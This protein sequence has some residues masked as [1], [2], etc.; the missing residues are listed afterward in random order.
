[1]LNLTARSR[2]A[3]S[4]AALFTLFAGCLE[5]DNI[6][7]MGTV[8]GEFGTVDL[9]TGDFTPLG[10]SGVT[11]AGM[12]VANATLYGSSYH[13]STGSLYKID[14]T[15]GS[16]AV[17]GTSSLD[18]DD[19]G[20]TTSGLFAVGLDR[21]LYSINAT[22]GAPTLI[23]PIG[24]SLG[25]WRSLSTNS[26]TLYFATGADLYTLSTTTGAATLVGSMGGP[27]MGAMLQESGILYGGENTPGFSVD[28]LN[29]TTG[30]ATTGPAV[31]G[32]SSSFFA[33]APNPLPSSPT[34]EPGTTALLAIGVASLGL[35][36]RR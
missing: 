2:L 31:T 25:A 21:N 12:A 28:T 11:L 13:T 1:L 18:I 29:P 6:A 20:S 30:A 26:N 14:P 22:T 16:L 10:N 27:E 34:P 4:F 35:V 15:N 17:I 7:Y 24:V 23:G 19:F 9:N 8:S 5:A 3:Y 32:T 33:L 36:R